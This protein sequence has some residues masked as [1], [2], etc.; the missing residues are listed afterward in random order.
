MLRVLE[1]GALA[2]VQDRGRRGYQRFG[3]PQ[4]GAVDAVAHAIANRLVGNPPEAASIEI[5]WG[6]AVFEVLEPCVFAVTGADLGARLAGATVPLWTSV[7]ARVGQRLAFLQRVRG[8]R[9]Y[10]ALAGGVD[11]PVVLG[12]RSTYLPGQFGGVEGRAL[13]PGDYVRVAAPPR[14]LA[15]WAARRWASPPTYTNVLRVLLCGDWDRAALAQPR[16]VGASS[17]RIGLRLEGVPLRAPTQSVDS[18]G[19]FPGV[20]QL[21]PDGQPIVLLA[22][23]QPTGGY[24][25]LGV[26][27]QADLHLAAQLLPGDTVWL[28]PVTRDEA[29]DA[30]REQRAWLASPIEEDDAFLSL[31]HVRA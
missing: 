1:G 15:R 2:T 25:V 10:L 30:L 24:P 12:S 22:D 7:Y 3:V 4:S 29:L 9:A 11:V 23:A 31:A 5:T 16:Q 18:F 21:P 19:V 27:I 17:N 6:G 20:I 26:V 8:G 14:D 13:R 28:M